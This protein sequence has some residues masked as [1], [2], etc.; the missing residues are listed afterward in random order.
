MHLLNGEP[1]TNS[2]EEAIAQWPET[3]TAIAIRLINDGDLEVFAPYG[4]TDLQNMEVRPT[5][6]HNTYPT[7]YNTRTTTKGGVPL[8]TN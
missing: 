3:A 8:G 4:V 6:Y 2:F 7:S 5:P 1:M